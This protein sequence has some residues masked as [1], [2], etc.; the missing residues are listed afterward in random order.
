MYLSA[1]VPSETTLTV[2]LSSAGSGGTCYYDTVSVK[3]VLVVVP[4]TYQVFAPST[5]SQTLYSWQLWPAAL[6]DAQCAALYA[7][8]R[9]EPE[10]AYNVE[11]AD[12]DNTDCKHKLYN[13]P[14]TVPAPLRVV[15][16]DFS[17]A[18]DYDQVAYGFRPLRIQTTHLWECESGTL[19]A[20]T[21][22]NVEAA[23]SGGNQARFTPASTSY[24]TQVTVAICANPADV[25][26]MQ[27]R[28]RLYLACYDSAAAVGI[29]LLKWRL[30]VAGVAE[31]YSD[32]FQA[33]AVSSRSVI[34]LGTLDIPPGAWPEESAEATTDVVGGS[35]ITLEIQVKN[36]AS[37][38]T[39]DLDA[40]YLVPAE[41][42]GVVTCT[43]LDN[44]D[45][46]LVID[47]ASAPAAAVSV[48]D[49]RSMEFATWG[50]IEG[51]AIEMTPV[52]GD[53]GTLWM[54]AYRNTTDQAFPND[55]FDVWLY[56]RPRW[57]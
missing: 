48:R 55:D 9:P 26:M 23:A 34:D 36:T 13:V 31:S 5:V 14:G 21:A 4:D 45:E 11:P 46:Y 16:G 37:T 10:L 19:G 33:T 57:L 6:T 32:E 47:W 38:G 20:Q 8:G 53:A 7:W 43:D 15:C 1:N 39:F 17:S 51:D 3:K 29:N 28:Y 24:G 49:Y 2:F 40:L 22:N 27:G 30:V 52:A 44:T 12:A 54:Y 50:V 35:F 42:E 56:Y 41:Q 18:T 25:A